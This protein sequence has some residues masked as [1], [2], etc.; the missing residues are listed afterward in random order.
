MALL[1]LPVVILASRE[2]LR[3]VPSGIREAAYALGS[4]RWQMI[5]RVVLPM[6]FPGILT[7]SILSISRALGETAPLVVVGALTFVAFLPTGVDSPFTVLPIQIFNWVSRPQKG[8]AE[9]AAAAIV[10]LL[11]VLLALNSAAIILRDR[12]QRRIS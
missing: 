11:A 6:A 12:L 5:R 10:L 3:T 8:F 2:A 9:N 7:G 1:I 4:T